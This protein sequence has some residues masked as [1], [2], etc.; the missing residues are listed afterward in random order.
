MLAG[1]CYL[2]QAGKRLPL[3]ATR[4]VLSIWGTHSSA[5]GAC[6]GETF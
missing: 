6:I 3:I 4:S 5:V 2:L 1:V